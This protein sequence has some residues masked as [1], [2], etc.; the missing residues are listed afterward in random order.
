M[1]KSPWCVRSKTRLEFTDWKV[2]HSLK[3]V[4]SFLGGKQCP[5]FV[6]QNANIIVP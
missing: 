3:E 5:D 4:L 1:T 2:K 6:V